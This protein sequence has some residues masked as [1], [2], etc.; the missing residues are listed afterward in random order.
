MGGAELGSVYAFLLSVIVSYMAPSYTDALI[1]AL[2]TYVIAR[3]F[4]VK[5]GMISEFG[6]G[7]PL[8]AFWFGYLLALLAFVAAQACV[9][10]WFYYWLLSR[11]Q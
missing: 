5:V 9:M 3:I 8:S 11:R 10:R 1:R 2:P 6:A 4:F 7:E